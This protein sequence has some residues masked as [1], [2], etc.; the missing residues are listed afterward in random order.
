MRR[1]VHASDSEVGARRRASIIAENTSLD[2]RRA[3]ERGVSENLSCCEKLSGDLGI[4]VDES[5][6]ITCIQVSA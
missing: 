5:W 1:S 6:A 2:P 3:E 4:P